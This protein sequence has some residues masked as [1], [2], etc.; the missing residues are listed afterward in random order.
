VR[1]PLR[2]EFEYWN[3]VPGAQLNL[4]VVIRT[5]EG[6]PIFSTSSATDPQWCDK[7][8][9]TGLFRS[10][11]DIPAD[12]FNDGVHRVQLDIRRNRRELICRLDDILVFDVLDAVE[13]RTDWFGK[14][15]GAVRPPLEWQTGM[16]DERVQP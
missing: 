14:W 6:Y 15:I 2:V 10:S 12:L 3:L 7:P 9:P 13:E 11:F 8:F 5:E 4:N 1:T 16:I